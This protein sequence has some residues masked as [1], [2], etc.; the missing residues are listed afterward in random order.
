MPDPILRIRRDWPRPDLALLAPFRDAPTGF[1]V[2]ARGRRGALDHRIRPV[3]R[4]ARFAGTALTVWTRARDNLAPYAALDRARPGDVLAVA[5]DGYEVASVVGDLLVG[6][7]RN[8]GIVAVVTDGLVRD[9]PGLDE[10]GIPVFALGVSPNSPQKDG[11]GEIGYPVSLG[12]V[13]LAPGDLLVGDGDGVVA[14]PRGM[15]PA[16]AAALEGVRAKEREMDAA[17][18][19][20]MRHPAWLAERLARPDVAWEG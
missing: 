1:V 18:R 7:A 9:V 16:A 19:G 14:V 6:M 15:L 10:V 2:D 20:G 13:V 3:T 17:V 4:A 5:T 11:P 8:C 12:G